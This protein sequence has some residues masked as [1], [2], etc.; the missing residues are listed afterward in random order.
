MDK[1]TLDV[2]LRTR[3]TQ[4]KYEEFLKTEAS[5]M[6]CFCRELDNKKYSRESEI[7]LDWKH[8]CAMENM[9]SYDALYKKHIMIFPKRHV[10]YDQLTIEE[11]RE[12]KHIMSKLRVGYHQQ[13]EN[14]GG[15]V[16]QKG[17]WHCHLLMFKD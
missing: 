1:E 15:K 9:Y 12:Y 13:L 3:K 11:V 5:H 6:C 2:T 17:H 10:N 7:I 14:L 8:W 16:S 4:A